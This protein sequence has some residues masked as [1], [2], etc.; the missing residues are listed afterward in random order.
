MPRYF[1]PHDLC[2]R[3][4]APPHSKRWGEI[5]KRVAV[6]ES[7]RY[8]LVFADKVRRAFDPT[9]L[10]F[11]AMPS[12]P[13][14]PRA[15]TRRSTQRGRS[16][17]GAQVSDRPVRRPAADNPVAGVARLVSPRSRNPAVAPPASG[18]PDP[19]TAEDDTSDDDRPLTSEEQYQHS[20]RDVALAFSD[21][22][23]WAMLT[24]RGRSPV[25]MD[26]ITRISRLMS[27]S[28]EE[29][30]S[31]D[32]NLGNQS[33]EKSSDSHLGNMSYD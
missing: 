29:E 6:L 28:G 10:S 27:E 4:T 20:L 23:Y 32:S 26:T 16:G 33:I 13:P 5:G 30:E 3:V 31:N 9:R 15:S 25:V 1:L 24:E 2:F 18:V 11:V 7:G 8:S 12:A 21:F 22:L 17:R 19:E 14:A